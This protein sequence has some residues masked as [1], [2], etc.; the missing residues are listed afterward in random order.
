MWSRFTHGIPIA[1][2]V[3]A[4]MLV[5]YGT[6]SIRALGQDACPEPNDSF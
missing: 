3:L 5:P 4:S 2:L 6:D 1:G